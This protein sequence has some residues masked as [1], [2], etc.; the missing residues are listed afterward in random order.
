MKGPSCE[1]FCSLGPHPIEKHGSQARFTDPGFAFQQY[2]LRLIVG[3]L[4]IEGH[5]SVEFR[6]SSNKGDVEQRSRGRRAL[7][8]PAL[9]AAR[10]RGVAQHLCQGD[11]FP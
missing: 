1:H 6:P 5:E 9:C 11:Q 4:L 2:N 3:N 7:A 10:S 8:E